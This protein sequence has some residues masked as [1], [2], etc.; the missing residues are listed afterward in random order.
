MLDL[1]STAND[2]HIVFAAPVKNVGTTTKSAEALVTKISA[3][4][5][6]NWTGIQDEGSYGVLPKQLCRQGKRIQK[7][8]HQVSSIRDKNFFQA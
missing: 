7:R 5:V 1:V 2:K 6:A 8:E 3:G 4:R